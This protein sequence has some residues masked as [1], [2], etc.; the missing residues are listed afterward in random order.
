MG[1]RGPAPKPTALRLIEGNRGKR[2]LNKS[3]PK[4]TPVRPTRPEW[5]LPEAKREWNRVVPELERM[6]LLTA[7]DRA[8][9]A[10]YCQ[11]YARAVQAE[12]VLR[13]SGISF[14]TPNGY[15]QQR[16]EVAIARAEWQM[17]RAFA[18]EFGFTPAARTRISVG[19]REETSDP[20]EA[21]L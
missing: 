19:K 3:E 11:A 12:A 7:V 20:M 5:M 6:G 4:P 9:L 18:S 21:Y 10:A 14:V 13:K 16:P 8:A 15:E 2:P 17:V 1:K